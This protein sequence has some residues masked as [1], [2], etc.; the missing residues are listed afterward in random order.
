MTFNVTASI[1]I[2][3]VAS[4]YTEAEDI[5][6]DADTAMYRAKRDGANRCVLYDASMHEAAL[7]NLQSRQQLKLAVER[8]EFVLFFQ[9][10][11]DLRDESLYGMEALIR[12]NHPSRGILAPG[13]FIALAE[14][15]GHIIAMGQWVLRQACRELAR[16]NALCDHDLVMSLN[17]ST[18]QLDIPTFFADLKDALHDSE[19]DPTLIQLEIT[20]S[21][22]LKDAERIGQLFRD[23]RALGVQIAFDDFG[24]GYSSLSYLERYP[25][26]TLKLDQ[27]FVQRMVKSSINAEIVQMVMQLARATGMKVSAEGV[28]EREQAAA[29]VAC[30]CHLAQGYLFSKPVPR[31]QMNA[32]V[33]KDME[34]RRRLSAR[35]AMSVMPALAGRA[36]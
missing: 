22:F 15:T 4:T 1:G 16:F 9:P 17:V 21:I 19:V 14:E 34:R 32:L 18:R 27:S 35:A 8:E 29:L 25:I 6:R 36:S 31:D 11:L 24:T 26:D 5:L 20:E 10:L 2:C 13:A 23:I 30:G 3:E 33:E 28:E 12:W 7:A